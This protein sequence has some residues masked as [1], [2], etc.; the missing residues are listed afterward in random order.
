MVTPALHP[1]C[2]QYI[3]HWIPHPRFFRI[4]IT[5]WKRRLIYARKRTHKKRF[6]IH[7]KSVILSARS[8]LPY[9][10]GPLSNQKTHKA[11]KTF[12]CWRK[13]KWRRPAPKK[14]PPVPDKRGTRRKNQSKSHL[15]QMLFPS[16]AW[17]HRRE[18]YS[19]WRPFCPMCRIK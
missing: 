4:S 17:G 8:I 5:R 9:I 12:S 7:P 16:C 14:R 1:F 19:L 11:R 2:I 13:R 10:S 3:R 18:G 15:K 6:R